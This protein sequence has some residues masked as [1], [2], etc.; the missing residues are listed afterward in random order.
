M[1]TFAVGGGGYVGLQVL[2]M[3]PFSFPTIFLPQSD[4]HI[5]TI[6]MRQKNLL[7][8]CHVGEKFMVRGG[9]ICWAARVYQ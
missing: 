2:S 8:G 6:L 4:C 3:S 1:E 5:E 9:G 7:I